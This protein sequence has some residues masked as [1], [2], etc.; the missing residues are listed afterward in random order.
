M[1][2]M[3]TYPKEYID[4]CRSKINQQLSA[5]KNLVEAGSNNEQLNTAFEVFELHFFNHMV[6]A[7]DHYFCHRSRTIEKKDGNPLNEVRMLCNS[8][9]EHENK[10]TVEK[11]IK[12]KPEKSVLKIE[13]GDEIKLTVKDFELLSKA[14]LDEMESKFLG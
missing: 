12:Y 8:I 4:E 11:S 10:L 14:F 5:Y 1:L 6:L 7:L 9:M 13:I 2:S 3:N